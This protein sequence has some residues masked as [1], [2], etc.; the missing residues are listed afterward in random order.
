MKHPDLRIISFILL[1]VLLFSL[2]SCA[3]ESIPRSFEEADYST[4]A[5][6]AAEQFKRID[7]IE[8]AF[9][10]SIATNGNTSSIGPNT[11][12]TAGFL[13]ISEKTCEE[14]F[15]E[16]D[17]VRQDPAFPE[18]IGTDVLDGNDFTWYRS[19]EFEKTVLGGS[20]IGEVYLD[21]ANGI[22]YLDVTNT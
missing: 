22:V 1:T 12:R 3:K 2:F 4:N 18:G 17:F 19:G 20:Y 21:K 11:Y 9:L 16:Y 8:S 5:S 7:G 13:V 15:N 6:G 14:Y 10:K